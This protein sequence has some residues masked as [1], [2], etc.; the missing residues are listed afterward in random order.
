MTTFYRGY[1]EP[2]STLY[3]Q[4]WTTCLYSAAITPEILH[5]A[6]YNDIKKE[7]MVATTTI[8]TSNIR[9]I[10]HGYHYNP[11]AEERWHHTLLVES[12]DILIITHVDLYCNQLYGDVMIHKN[13]KALPIIYDMP[14][15][16]YEG[17]DGYEG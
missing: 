10:Y 6:Y 14:Y 16:D 5:E 8:D 7:I 4:W 9:T 15:A 13:A 12:L 2:K 3:G 17:F 1:L 11:D